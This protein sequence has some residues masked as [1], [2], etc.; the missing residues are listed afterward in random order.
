MSITLNAAVAQAAPVAASEVLLYR[1]PAKLDFGIAKVEAANRGAAADSVR[2]RRAVQNVAS[3]N[4]QFKIYDTAI[5]AQDNMEP[6]S[7][8]VRAGDAVYVRATLGTVSFEI[9]VLERIKAD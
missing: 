5:P 2:L 7:F 4:E 3:A 6:I 9:N 1:A 8:L